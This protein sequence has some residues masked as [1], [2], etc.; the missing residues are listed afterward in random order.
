MLYL[1]LSTLEKKVGVDYIRSHL[2]L[3]MQAG[4]PDE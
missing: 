3:N 1:A 2:S 4:T